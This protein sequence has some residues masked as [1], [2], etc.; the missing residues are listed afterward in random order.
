MLSSYCSCPSVSLLLVSLLFMMACG[1]NEAT[2]RSDSNQGLPSVNSE[3]LS[4]GSMSGFNGQRSEVV[5]HEQEQF[6]EFWQSLSGG[7]NSDEDSIPDVDFDTF[8]VVGVSMGEQPSSGYDITIQ[9][10]EHQEDADQ[11]KVSVLETKPGPTCMNMTVM[12]HPHHIIK[13][14]RQDAELVFDYQTEVKDCD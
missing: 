14:N 12:T 7:L 4:K 3:T 9:A 11:L 2:Q 6:R 1:S 8:M 13:L 10:I 5:I